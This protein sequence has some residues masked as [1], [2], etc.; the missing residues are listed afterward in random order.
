MWA[1]RRSFSLP[2]SFAAVGAVVFVAAALLM[3]WLH[4]NMSRTHMVQMA[5]E[6]NAALAAAFSNLLRDDLATLLQE[7]APAAGRLA[8]FDRA[9]RAAAQ[10][11]LIA[12]VKVYDAAGRTVYSSDPAQIGRDESGNPGFLGAM[13]GRRVSQL[14]RRDQ[15]VHV[16]HAQLLRQLAPHLR[17][18]QPDLPLHP[19]VDDGGRLTDGPGKVRLIPLVHD[20]NVPRDQIA[21]FHDARSFS[22]TPRLIS[23]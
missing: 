5:E 12:K 13:E 19:A 4:L 7:A 16:P 20:S 6:S 3:T 10:G 17:S 9:V 15:N 18:G 11:T 14:T 23:F 8:A 2:K 1:L 21:Q 22:E